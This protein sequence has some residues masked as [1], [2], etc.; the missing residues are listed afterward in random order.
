MRCGKNKL[1]TRPRYRLEIA[2]LVKRTA[3]LAYLPAGVI[4]A[5]FLL[6]V[7]AVYRFVDT[8]S[9]GFPQRWISGKS[10]PV[11]HKSFLPAAKLSGFRV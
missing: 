10:M 11:S 8:F 3:S 4:P 7:D 1:L 2:G 9:L 6:E 5:G